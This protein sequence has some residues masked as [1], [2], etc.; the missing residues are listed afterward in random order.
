MLF[1][2]NLAD[3]PQ[4]PAD[5]ELLVEAAIINAFSGADGGPRARIGGTIYASRFY[6][7]VALLGS[8][9][10]IVSILIGSN[11]SPGATFTGSIAGTTLTVSA[12]A[13]GTLAIGQTI[14]DVPGLIIA[15]TTITAFVGGSG[16]T[17]TYTVSET[18]TVG[19]RTMIGAVASANLV[20][21]KIDQVPTTSAAYIKVSLL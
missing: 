14:S 9:A 21:V 19:S 17:G 11:N 15:G 13:S 7:A 6:S 3:N 4:V 8:W 18:Q 10:Q 5:A 2:V 16:G 12:V 20:D 1:Q